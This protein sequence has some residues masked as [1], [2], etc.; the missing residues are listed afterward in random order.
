M[1]RQLLAVLKE[2]P[3]RRIVKPV[4][5]A[6]PFPPTVKSLWNAV[7]Y[8]QYLVEGWKSIAMRLFGWFRRRQPTPEQ[9]ARLARITNPQQRAA[10]LKAVADGD[11]IPKYAWDPVPTELDTFALL[12][13]APQAAASRPVVG[14]SFSVTE[15][16]PSDLDPRTNAV[17]AVE[18]TRGPGTT[19][20]ADSTIGI[21]AP[22]PV[23][24]PPSRLMTD[25]GRLL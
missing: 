6:L 14:C 1:R 3:L 11:V 13:R 12:P 18:D 22:T 24:K 8:P 9:E 2:P 7:E 5:R 20:G 21:N 25:C 10:L 16:E 17:K 4:V 23:P 19:G 15:R